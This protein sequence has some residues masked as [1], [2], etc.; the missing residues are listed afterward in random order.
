MN[1]SSEDKQQQR[2]H[3]GSRNVSKSVTRRADRL[4]HDDETGA[5]GDE[6]GL[7]SSRFVQFVAFRRNER[8]LSGSRWAG[9]SGLEGPVDEQYCASSSSFPVPCSSQN[10]STCSDFIPGSHAFL[11]ASRRHALDS[12]VKENGLAEK[13]KHRVLLPTNGRSPTPG[14]VPFPLAYSFCRSSN[15]VQP[16]SRYLPGNTESSS[17]SVRNDLL[18]HNNTGNQFDAGYTEEADAYMESHDSMAAELVSEREAGVHLSFEMDFG[19]AGGGSVDDIGDFIEADIPQNRSSSLEFKSRSNDSVMSL[20]EELTAGVTTGERSEMGKVDPYFLQDPASVHVHDDV[21]I[22]EAVKK[23]IFG[24]EEVNNLSQ[25]GRAAGG[26]QNNLT[27]DLGAVFYR[28]TRLSQS[29]SLNFD[30]DAAGNQGKCW[31]WSDSDA[32]SSQLPSLTSATSLTSDLS[33]GTP[34]VPPMSPLSTEDEAVA[35]SVMSSPECLNQLPLRVNKC[36]HGPECLVAS[37]SLDHNGGDGRDDPPWP[38]ESVSETRCNCKSCNDLSKNMNQTSSKHVIEKFF[39][40]GTGPNSDRSSG[41][42]WTKHLHNDAAIDDGDS[43]CPLGLGRSRDPHHRQRSSDCQR[44]SASFDGTG[45]SNAESIGSPVNRPYDTERSRKDATSEESFLAQMN[46]RRFSCQGLLDADPLD[47]QSFSRTDGRSR[48]DARSETVT[49]ALS[50][51]SLYSTQFLKSRPISLQLDSRRTRNCLGGSCLVVRN[52]DSSSRYRADQPPVVGSEFSH[53]KKISTCVKS[54]SL[55]EE[56]KDDDFTEGMNCRAH[57]RNKNGHH[58]RFGNEMRDVVCDLTACDTNL[59]RPENDILKSGLVVACR[60]CPVSCLLCLLGINDFAPCACDLFP[61]NGLAEKASLPNYLISCSTAGISAEQLISR[62]SH[63]TKD[64]VY[65]KFFHLYPR[66]NIN[67]IAWLKYWIRK[68]AVPLATRKYEHPESLGDS[69]QHKLLHGAWKPGLVGDHHL[70]EDVVV[71]EWFSSDSS[72]RINRHH[73]VSR[74]H[75]DCDLN[76]LVTHAD[77]RWHQMNVLGQVVNILREERLQSAVGGY[78]PQ[79][80]SHIV[81]PTH[82]KSGVTLYIRTDSAGYAELESTTPDLPVVEQLNGSADEAAM[83]ALA[84]HDRNRTKARIRETMI[85]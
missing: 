16:L 41:L 75:D 78:R 56:E 80:T 39:A 15:N 55:S 82:F 66:R 57:R 70:S 7:G 59:A 27:G 47:F 54:L 62:V 44:M 14:D 40:W 64:L 34:S 10:H 60:A 20:F 37:E 52:V 21:G 85:I 48:N 74:W 29:G 69:W 71:D 58:C 22:S 72:L 25:I 11:D 38:A 45:I 26:L 13:V 19:A 36:S 9:Y 63:L 1:E 30:K 35:S 73:V 79:L 18:G 23:R 4:T 24:S 68:G 12:C 81:V 65:G 51:N 77:T 33:C 3:S 67:L 6:P 2:Q 42:P 76:V 28:S 31:R 46:N 17:T 61:A 32:V 83:Q 43:C 50:E 49:S 8:E 53:R 5:E 84:S